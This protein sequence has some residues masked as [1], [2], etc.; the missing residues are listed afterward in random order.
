[1]TA[2]LSTV[3]S[4]LGAGL[5]TPAVAP[6]PED[7]HR[8]RSA[9]VWPLDVNPYPDRDSRIVLDGPLLR[10]QRAKGHEGQKH[11]RKEILRSHNDPQVGMA[12]AMGGLPVS[13]VWPS[14]ITSKFLQFRP[15]GPVG[16]ENPVC[17]E[18]IDVS[19]LRGSVASMW[20]WVRIVGRGVA[21]ALKSRRDL[22]LEN[23]ALRHQ[24]I[25]LQ[26]E[27]DRPQ[28][29]DPDRLFWVGLRCLWQGWRRA[30]CLVQPATVACKWGDEPPS[31]FRLRTHSL[32]Q[33]LR[34]GPP[35]PKRTWTRSWPCV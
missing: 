28:P 23:L 24:L 25:V 14:A 9:Y 3:S 21:S 8:N 5:C 6:P 26:R 32:D 22:A 27:A 7:E 16:G 34:G 12:I 35:R 30:L 10:S 17:R 33:V 13:Y 1:M 31:V 4:D 29:K 19:R 2:T 20:E 18:I 15:E 11:R